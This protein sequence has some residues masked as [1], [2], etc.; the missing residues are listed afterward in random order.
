M[1]NN[2]IAKFNVV[3]MRNAATLVA[4]ADDVRDSEKRISRIREDIKN[5]KTDIENLTHTLNAEI[6]KKAASGRKMLDFV[7]NNW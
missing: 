7:A 1:L 3:D 4:L 6:D 5:L 2:T